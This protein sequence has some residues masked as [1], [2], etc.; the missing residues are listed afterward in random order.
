MLLVAAGLLVG[1]AALRVSHAEDA[2]P[3]KETG[4]VTGKVVDSDNNPVKDATVLIVVPRAPKPAPT[5]AGDAPPKRPAPVAKG[6]TGEDGTFK[7]ENVPVGKYRVMAQAEGKG[8]GRAKDS[9]EVKAK[10]TVDA[11]TITLQVPQAGGGAAK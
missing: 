9:V 4:T 5:A 7:I 2:A 8:R 6:T 10:E 3:A 1:S 11:G